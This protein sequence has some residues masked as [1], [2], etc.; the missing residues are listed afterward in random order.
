M[1]DNDFC[2]R[3]TISDDNNC[4]PRY[5]RMR[6]IAKPFLLRLEND[7]LKHF[8]KMCCTSSAEIKLWSYL[9][10]YVRLFKRC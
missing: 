8:S 4:V 5:K 3:P 2:G 9:I 6:R 10:M 1:V 7:E